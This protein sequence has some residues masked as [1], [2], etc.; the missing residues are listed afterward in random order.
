[1]FTT[2][3]AGFSLLEVLVALIVLSVGVLAA[4]RSLAVM[5]H[6]LASAAILTH[7]A[8]LGS[9]QMEALIARGCEAQSDEGETP[10]GGVNVGWFVRSTAAGSVRLAVVLRYPLEYVN[11]VDSIVHF[12][13]CSDEA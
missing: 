4:A 2:S 9:N 11:R 8:V 7:V 13:S 12:L 10:T 6:T 5:N 3:K 1:M